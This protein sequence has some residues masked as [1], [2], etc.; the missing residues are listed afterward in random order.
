MQK[1]II[2]VFQ[3]AELLRVHVEA[4]ES[5][6]HHV[7][8]ARNL[9][10]LKK[11]LEAGECDVVVIGPTIPRQEKLRIAHFV[12]QHAPGYHLIEVYGDSPELE[13][14]HDHIPHSEGCL[15][16]LDALSRIP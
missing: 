1:R 11:H 10:E 5:A 14:A 2:G 9:H 8:P 12:K 6:G 15:L 3:D 7:C 16:L 4:L 13:M